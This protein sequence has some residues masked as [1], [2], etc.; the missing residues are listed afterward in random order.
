MGRRLHRSRVFNR[1]K[2]AEHAQCPPPGTD[3]KQVPPGTKLDIAE[4][5]GQQ[6][7]IYQN[8]DLALA[9]CRKPQDDR[10]LPHDRGLHETDD[11]HR[12]D[13]IRA[14]IRRDLD[15]RFDFGGGGMNQETLFVDDPG[16]TEI[17]VRVDDLAQ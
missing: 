13:G 1:R 10:F 17:G 15:R 12:L 16:F 4:E 8:I 9:S 11:L 6:T 2:G 7:G 5:E 3:E 14:L